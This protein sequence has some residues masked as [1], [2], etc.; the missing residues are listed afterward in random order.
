[1]QSSTGQGSASPHPI[2][3]GVAGRQWLH[4]AGMKGDVF[5]AAFFA[6]YRHDDDPSGFI[7]RRTL[8]AARMGRNIAVVSKRSPQ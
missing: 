2:G 8:T 5:G 7:R 3:S 1:M 4:G 6:G